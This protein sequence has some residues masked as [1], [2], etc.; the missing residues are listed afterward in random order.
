MLA[1]EAIR[2]SG[3]DT[4]KKSIRINKLILISSVVKTHEKF[5]D[6]IGKGL[7]KEVHNFCSYGDEVCR[8]NPF[9][10]SGYNGFLFGDSEPNPK[11]SN[12]RY[13]VE[14]SQWFDD[15]PPDFYKIFRNVLFK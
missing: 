12:R 14:H 13:E 6:T 5:N 3:Q 7:I 11:V 10:H 1:Y 4:R 15:A 8:F 9:G 2:W